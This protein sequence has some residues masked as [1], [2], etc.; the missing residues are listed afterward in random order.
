MGLVGV[1]GCGRIGPDVGVM[2]GLM[3]EDED[4]VVVGLVRC[5]KDRP[6][7]WG[8]MDGERMDV[9]WLGWVVVGVCGKDRPGCWG[10]GERMGVELVGVGGGG[11]WEG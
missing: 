7:C 11:V 9:G 5:G 1:V 6:G 3:R 2:D 4:G 10:D 8:V